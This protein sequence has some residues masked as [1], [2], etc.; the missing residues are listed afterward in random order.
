MYEE[1]TRYVSSRLSLWCP[2]CGAKEGQSC[3]PVNGLRFASH[4][5]YALGQ[6]P[7]PVMIPDSWDNPMRQP[8]TRHK[9]RANVSMEEA[10]PANRPK[11]TPQKW[12]Q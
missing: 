1:S 2:I 9:Y 6:V 3:K 7:R 5:A 8:V 12:V 4:D 11:W 10:V